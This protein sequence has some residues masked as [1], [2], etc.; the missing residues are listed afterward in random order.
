M[1]WVARTFWHLDSRSFALAELG[2][3]ARAGVQRASVPSSRSV[4]YPIEKTLKKVSHGG[5]EPQWR[6]SQEPMGVR[7][8]TAPTSPRT[9]PRAR[10]AHYSDPPAR[11]GHG[12]REP[13]TSSPPHAQAHSSCA[14]HTF[15]HTTHLHDPDERA[16]ARRRVRQP[17][18]RPSRAPAAQTRAP[19]HCAARS[20]RRD[21]PPS[22]P[23]C[24]SL[25]AALPLPHVIPHTPSLVF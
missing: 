15:M 16:R 4:R 9:S 6:R 25:F 20:K 10:R 11:D 5:S 21:A 13:R 19:A 22:P 12:V 8:V 7:T 2:G 17:A 1:P 23:A 18:A 14:L 3:V 24:L